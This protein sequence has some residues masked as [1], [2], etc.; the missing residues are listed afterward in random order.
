ML[1]LAVVVFI[2]I[3]III[4]L[5]YVLVEGVGGTLDARLVPNDENI[6]TE[7]GV[8]CCVYCYPVKLHGPSLPSDDELSISFVAYRGSV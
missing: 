2:A 7:I 4:L 6:R 8:S 3:D 1:V 5:V